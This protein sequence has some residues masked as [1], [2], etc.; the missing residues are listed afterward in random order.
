MI[1]PAVNFIQHL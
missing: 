1:K